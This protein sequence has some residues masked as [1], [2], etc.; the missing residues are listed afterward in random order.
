[1]DAYVL[2]NSGDADVQ[3]AQR[4]LNASFFQ[5][6]NFF[7]GPCDGH[8]SRGVQV[9]LAQALQYSM[10]LGDSGADGN[11]GAGTE[12]AMKA[13][14]QVSTSSGPTI[15]VQLFRA[16]MTFNNRP[17]VWQGAST[18]FTSGLAD[19]VRDF[20]S[21][22]KLTVNGQGDYETWMS[23]LLSTGDPTRKGKAIDVMYPLTSTTIATVKG[24][25][26]EIVG[27]YLTGGT[28]KVLTNSEIALIIDNGMSFFP[29]YQ[30]FGDAVTYFSY[31]QGVAAGQAAYAAAKGFTVPD[32]TT[33]YFS[34]DFDAPTPRS[35]ARSS[36]I[37]RASTTR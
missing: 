18:T 6:T 24:A 27:R 11:I 26:Y 36:P 10:G 12:A 37:S 22:G 29:L 23:L 13:Q 5:R 4:W 9:V 17:N 25:G 8:Y 16:A 1:M 15:F 19:S 3:A 14:A 21:F 30:E 35:P 33:L 7:I 20:Q 28:N 2:V 34:V 31:D 32:G